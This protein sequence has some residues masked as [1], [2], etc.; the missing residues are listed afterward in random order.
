MPLPR[1]SFR[2]FMAPGFLKLIVMRR[3]FFVL[4]RV[5][6]RQSR[7]CNDEFSHPVAPI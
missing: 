4:I 1:L 7:L 3:L 6:L 2:L 5:V